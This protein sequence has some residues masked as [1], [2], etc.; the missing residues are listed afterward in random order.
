MT[1]HQTEQWKPVPSLL[2]LYELSSD[3]RLRNAKTKR[4]IKP[5]D[6]IAFSVTINGRTIR[7]NRQRLLYN[8]FGIPITDVR[9]S[10]AIT[11]VIEKDGDSIKFGTINAASDFIEQEHRKYGKGYRVKW[12]LWHRE[13]VVFGFN[14]SYF[15][16][17][18]V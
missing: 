17:R 8:L 2:N 9:L 5:A 6:R 16:H 7:V 13:P 3:G 12:H 18:G 4:L 15:D 1:E 14:V 11:C 10:N